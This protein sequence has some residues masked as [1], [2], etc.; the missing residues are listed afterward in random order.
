MHLKTSMVT[1]DVIKDILA[2]IKGNTLV[3]WY[4]FREVFSWLVVL[5]LTAL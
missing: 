5:G 3:N 1:D 4:I 2:T